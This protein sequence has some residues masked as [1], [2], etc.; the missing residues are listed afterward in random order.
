MGSQPP[1]SNRSAVEQAV[2]GLIRALGLDPATEPELA[3]TPARVAELY[4]EIFR[5]LAPDAMPEPAT[6]AHPGGD[7]LVVVRDLPFH[8]L[9]VH[10]FVPF[11]GRALVAYLPGERIIGISGAA[12]LLL[13]YARRPQLQ[14]RITRQVAD[15][16]ERL[17]SPRGLA[18]V[19]QARHLCMEMRGVR[20][21]G[22]VETRVVR[23]ALADARWAEALR[24]SPGGGPGA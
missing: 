18:V 2:A 6:F 15:H 4:A 10:H 22:V 1:G 11:F 9:C 5:G 12:R 3:Q 16:L 23:G 19:L 14:E 17:L 21:P 8:S 20:S 13:H 24:M 7:D